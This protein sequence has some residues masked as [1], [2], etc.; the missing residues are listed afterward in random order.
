MTLHPFVTTDKNLR[1]GS[2]DRLRQFIA[3]HPD[4][5]VF[6]AYDPGGL[7]QTSQRQNVRRPA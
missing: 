5:R 7:P 2:Q 1:F 4:V 6:A 3:D